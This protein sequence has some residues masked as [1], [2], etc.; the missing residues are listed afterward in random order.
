MK[1]FGEILSTLGA[2][3]VELV[4]EDTNWDYWKAEF[5]TPVQVVAG[6]YLYLKHD[7]P[8]NEATPRNLQQWRLDSSNKGYEII[9]TPKS[10]LAKNIA[11]TKLT[12]K[13]NSAKT[14]KQLLLD[15]FIKGLDWKPLGEEEYFVD[16]SIQL[17]SGDIISGAKAFLT[18]WFLG[19]DKNE[20]TSPLA[21][22]TAN[23]GVGK[24]TLSRI[25]C[26]EMRRRDPSVIP[27][28][29][30]SDQW[31]SLLQ[32]SFTL[33]AVWDLAL[34]RRFENASRLLANK[35]ALQVLIREGL[36]VV[37]FDGFDELCINP[38]S[39]Y[40]P[41]DLITELR[42][43]FTPEDT[44][45]EARVLL[46]TRETYW[47]T[48]ED[49]L[50]ASQLIVFKLKEFDNDQKKFYFENRLKSQVKRDLAFRI[51]KQ[52]SGAVYDGLQVEQ[53]N[54]DRL[55]GVPFILDLIAR[56]VEEDDDVN[57][58]EA[59]SL[60][61]LLEGI[62]R[63]ENKRQTLGLEP[64]VQITIFEEIFREHPEGISLDDLALYLQIIGNI[65]EPGVVKRFTN[66]VLLVQGP[67]GLYSP[68]Y[69]VL[70]VYFLARFLANGL[71]DSVSGKNTQRNKIARE[72][73]KHST[74][75][76]QLMDWLVEQLNNRDDNQL[77]QAFSH[78]IEIS[79][80]K[81]N[82]EVRRSSEMAIC[83][84]A[85]RFVGDEDKLLRTLKFGK[86]LGAQTADDV[87]IF[88]GNIFS[89]ELRAFNFT[90]TKFKNCTFIDVEFKNCV[91]SKETIFTG[92]SFEGGL[93]FHN[94]TGDKD[95]SISE[96]SIMSREAE[97][98]LSQIRNSGSRRELRIS[99]A[100]DVMNRALRR[101]KSDYGL[102]GIQYRHRKSGFKPGNPYNEKIWEILESLKIVERHEISN[103]S[104]GGLHVRDDKDL[105]RDIVSFLDNG[106][107]GTTLRSA[108]D[109][110]VA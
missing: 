87:I 104:E 63:R 110:L 69:E 24:T 34:T 8:K 52:I 75:K 67:N 72:L 23:G 18:K 41:K 102:K 74:G 65:N 5:V 2:S 91:F 17:P 79:R 16:P 90:N 85:S 89:G 78:A 60:G 44:A 21:V 99:F 54:Q 109:K 76:T 71:L 25:L 68:R 49:Q 14:T 6:Y 96:D 100:E 81:E 28:L 37:V 30:E 12:F 4:K 43:L 84:L 9:V 1:H 48:I 94:C 11:S 42:E 95:I 105:K 39:P 92:C 82:S 19:Q 13:G 83:H 77:V 50:D 35:T 15:S 47:S 22:L 10:D 62:C 108:I 20:N 70:R 3:S 56:D 97:Y 80:D 32:G 101:F 40:T 33:D 45:C 53:Q 107:V 73:A 46:T 106:V 58:Y 36:F 86:L 61:T 103:V 51:S 88:N 38:A 55:S 26:S 98:T 59:D 57:P 29:I 27:I 64:N 7:C 31:R 66:H 93:E